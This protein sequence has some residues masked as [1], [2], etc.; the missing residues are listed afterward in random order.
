MSL[1]IKGSSSSAIV[2]RANGTSLHF[3]LRKFAIVIGLN[4]VSNR[5]DFIFDEDIPNRIVEKY[6]NGKEFIQK[7]QL[8]LAFMEKVWRENNDEDAEKFAILYF[9]HFFVLSNV[10]TVVIP[11]LYFDPVDSERYKDFYGSKLESRVEEDAVSKAESPVEEETFISK[12]VFDAFCDEVRQEFEGIHRLVTKKFNLMLK[13]IEQSKISDEKTD[14][15]NL[16]DSQFTIPDEMLPSLNAYQRESITT[17]PSITHVEEPI[18]ENLNDKM[19]E[20]IVEDDCQT[21]KENVGLSSKSELHGEVD[22]CTEEQIMT[23]PKIQ[24]L[25]T[26][27]QRDESICPDSQN[28][29]PDELLPSLNVYSSKSIIVHL[30]DNREFQTP[31]QKLR[32]RRPS[33]FKE[34]PYTRRAQ[35]GTYIYSPRNIHLFI[36]PI[37]GTVDTKMVKKFMVWISVNLL[38]GHAKRFVMNVYSMDDPNLNARG[39]ED[40]LNEYINGF[41]MHTA[42]PW[43]TVKDIYIPVNIK[44]KYHWVLAVLFFSERCIF[45]FDSYESSGHYTVVLPEIKKIS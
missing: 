44:E 26:D 25:T 28:T 18:D 43:H 40:H 1:E 36:T 30:Y 16:S 38:K 8:F 27:G 4:C 45:L 37:D 23:T 29:I 13:E 6:F 20:S 5:Y 22:L 3:N 24:E 9:L 39:Q 31:V 11:R 7:K 12:K 10:N 34:S 41:R 42:V 14:E 15:I 17:H 19:S 33:K 2:I 21:N 32:I 35:Q